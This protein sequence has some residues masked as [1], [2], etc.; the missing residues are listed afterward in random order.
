MKRKNVFESIK[1]IKN[2]P[3]PKKP[4]LSKSPFSKQAQSKQSQG[5]KIL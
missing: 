3:S 4:M 2:S 1:S 5:K